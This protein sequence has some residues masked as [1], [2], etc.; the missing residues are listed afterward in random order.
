MNS[1]NNMLEL[2]PWITAEFVQSLIEKS[3][4]NK[5]VVLKLFNAKKCFNDGE[6]FSSV[7]V[8]LEV[9]YENENESEDKQRDF[10]LKI[11]IQTEDYAK[12]CEECLIYEREIEAYTKVLPAV[13][14]SLNSVGVSSQIAPRCFMADIDRRM[15][16]FEDLRN[17]QFKSVDRTYGLDTDHMKLTLE[18]LAKWHAGTVTLLLTDIELFEW[19]TKRN[20]YKNAPNVQQFWKNLVKSLSNSI[21]NWT[22][23]EKIAVKLQN[24]PQKAYDEAYKAFAPRADAFNV[25]THGDMFVNNLLYRHD[26]HGKPIDIRFVDFPLGKHAS[27]SIDLVTLL[28]SSSHSSIRQRDREH[29]IQYYH[30]ELVKYLKLLKFPGKIPTLLDI[31]SDCYRIDLFTTLIILFIVAL[32]FVDKFHDGGFFDVV[33]GD[34]KDGNTSDKLF[35]HPECTEQ[36]KYLLD[37]FDRRGYFDF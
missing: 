32:R 29:L 9:V 26:E 7:M 3:E 20:V 13:E 30:S 14:K 15:L 28:Y 24:I 6:N 25:L 36:V 19:Y 8:G 10:L 37:M 23:Y 31:Q 33:N 16:V 12:I 35:S 27:P 2:F 22:G 4:P 18:N 34:Q 1:H 21:K 11:A 17:Q 5:N